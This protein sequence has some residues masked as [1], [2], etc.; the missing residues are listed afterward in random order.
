VL[1]VSA[2]IGDSAGGTETSEDGKKTTSRLD[3]RETDKNEVWD[4]A[5]Q[6]SGAVWSA[7]WSAVLSAVL[8]AGLMAA[9]AGGERR[10]VHAGMTGCRPVQRTEIVATRPWVERE[11]T[12]TCRQKQE[13]QPNR[14]A[15]TRMTAEQ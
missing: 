13:R 8:S 15:A 10:R 7:V 14:C 6:T 12:V 11:R 3:G 4:R 9:A 2:V 1:A 5:A